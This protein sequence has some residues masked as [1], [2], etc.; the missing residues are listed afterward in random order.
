MAGKRFFIVSYKPSGELVCKGLKKN[1]IDYVPFIAET[2]KYL[3]YGPMQRYLENIRGFFYNRKLKQALKQVRSSDVLLMIKGNHLYD[4]TKKL[5]SKADCRKL[6][7]TLDSLDRA[8]VQKDICDFADALILQDAG[9]IKKYPSKKSVHL[10]LG[11]DEDVFFPMEIE[12][13]IDVCL[14]GNFY[15]GLYKNRLELIKTLGSDQR[16]AGKKIVV[17]GSSGSASMNESLK[18]EFPNIDFLGKL[19]FRE[20]S[21]VLNRSKVAVNLH[22]N[23]GIEPVNPWLFMIAGTKTCQVTDHR[24]Y[25]E[26]YFKNGTEI[27]MAAVSEV[28][29]LVLDLLS[30]AARRDQIAE[31]GYMRAVA[32]HSSGSRARMIGAMA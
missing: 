2:P 12:K 14:V 32:D 16:F 10:P 5:L 21:N 28:P 29:S 25:L 7:M 22:Q 4:S 18:N 8:I 30:D 20:I 23:D 26:Q 19:N 31:N 15:P 27:L 3:S 1:N 17:I 9:D 6:A 24:T 13:D 11:Y